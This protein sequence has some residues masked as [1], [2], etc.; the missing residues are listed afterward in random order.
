LQSLPS[1]AQQDNT[2]DGAI[3]TIRPSKIWK[4]LDP[5][6]LQQT[7]EDLNNQDTTLRGSP[8]LDTTLR[9]TRH[10]IHPVD[11][12]KGESTSPTTTD[13]STLPIAIDEDQEQLCL[14]D[15]LTRYA[16]TDISWLE[17][18]TRTHM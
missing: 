11:E 16:S 9:V 7:N 18:E 17:P 8:A 14:T 10:I 13:N 2:G 5:H 6:I 15:F 4:L 12:L 3:V 1:Q